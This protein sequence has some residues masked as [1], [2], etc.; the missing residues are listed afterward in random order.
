M[1]DDFDGDME[2]LGFRLIR[3]ADDFVILC[4]NAEQARQ[5]HSAATASLAEH[6]LSLNPVKTHR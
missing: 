3:F 4:K 6:G 2:V 5:A 1:L